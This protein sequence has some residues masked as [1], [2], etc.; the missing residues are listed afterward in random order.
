MTVVDARKAV[1]Q[2]I[3]QLV[4]LGG[5]NRMLYYRDLTRGTIR[6]D[7]VEPRVIDLLLGGTDTGLKSYAWTDPVG[8]ARR[9]K[10]IRAKARENLEEEGVSTLFLAMGLA[11]WESSR[12]Q[13]PAAPVVFWPLNVSVEF[14]GG[15][16]SVQVV[17]EPEVNPA[18]ELV[19]ELD[20]GVSLMDP[21]A[22]DAGH[23]LRDI[24]Q[25][26][27][28]IDVQL[29]GV[30]GFSLNRYPIIIGNFSYEKLAMV[31][32]LGIDPAGLLDHPLVAAIAGDQSAG[33]SLAIRRPTHDALRDAENQVNE[34]L[35]L[36]ADPTQ[37]AI[38]GRVLAGES[39]VIEGPPGTGKSQTIAN[40]V[41]THAAHGRSVLFVA[42]KRAAID[43]VLK[44]LEEVGLANLVLDLHGAT[45][46]R[47]R[48]ASVLGEAVEQAEGWR[49]HANTIR[50]AGEAGAG[51][52]GARLERHTRALHRVDEKRGCSVFEALEELGVRPDLSEVNLSEA[53]GDSMTAAER[54]RLVGLLSEWADRGGATD[55]PWTRQTDAAGAA[56]LADKTGEVKTRLLSLYSDL[57][58]A[59]PSVDWMQSTFRQAEKS[60]RV[61]GA[62]SDLLDRYTIGILSIDAASALEA[63]EAGGPEEFTTTRRS[64]AEHTKADIAVEQVSEDLL[65]VSRVR[66]AADALALDPTAESL[67]RLA[68]MVPKMGEAAR[69]L[70][71]IRGVVDSVLLDRPFRELLAR[72]E[73]LVEQRRIATNLPEIH[74]LERD[75]SAAGLDPVL[76]AIRTGSETTASSAVARRA[77]NHAMLDSMLRD[78]STLSSFDGPTLSSSVVSFRELENRRLDAAPGRIQPGV[79]AH[80]ESAVADHPG[81]LQAVR[82]EANKAR[83]HAPLRGIIEGASDVLLAARPC[84]AMSPLMVSQLLPS[85]IGL[86]DVVVFDEASQ[87]FPADALPAIFRGKQVVIAGDR[88]QLPPTTFFMSGLG[89]DEGVADRD[90]GLAADYQSILD[91]A[92]GI[93][94]VGSLGWHYRSQDDRLVAYSNTQ[95]Y[96]GALLTFPGVGVTSAV[97]HHLVTE[98][99]PKD[100]TYSNPHEVAEVVDLILEHARDRPNESLGVVAMGLEH[101]TEITLSVEDRLRGVDSPVIR[102]FFEDSGAERFLVKNLERIQGDERDAI[103]VSLGYAPTPDGKL[104]HNFGPINQVGG[105]RRLNVAVTRAK[106]RMTVVSSFRAADV[107]LSRSRSA[108]VRALKGF[109]Q[110]A[111]AGGEPVG[112]H[113]STD[114]G[115]MVRTITGRLTGAGLVAREMYGSSAAAVDVAVADPGDP[116]RFVA[117]ITLDGRFYASLPTPGDR[118]RL[119]AEVLERMGWRVYPTWALAWHRDPE[120]ELKRLV[121][122]IASK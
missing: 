121:E 118:D 78:N 43:A 104:R 59:V 36:D 18:L 103:I 116:G 9:I 5:R 101:A 24:G 95:F 97:Q 28:D 110:Y 98:P 26:F 19:M 39:L 74:R 112:G 53:A 83:R 48:M 100:R 46:T 111:E 57:A 91:L 70:R 27:D 99:A 7:D 10:A 41:A 65:L 115:A 40:L 42:E 49:G 60:C 66:E 47:R 85:M 58:D 113:T 20:F 96:R 73:A 56:E 107:D 15:E 114:V 92:Y 67:S 94:P 87:V 8:A 122:L 106:R 90:L 64:L 68:G 29:A 2:W 54:E 23:S 120:A 89:E 55:S 4:D 3:K 119:R 1:D 71:R 32:D 81:Q 80:L 86:F 72:L 11:T 62:A 16:P 52:P 63:L 12:R 37:R 30:P 14:A 22:L 13:D 84:W 50:D 21:E 117:A 82:S 45:T 44:R 102:S 51:D 17:G 75:L 109:L 25:A 61:A 35:I 6:L 38:L 31:E 69:G 93:L 108:G 76:E 77:L 33:E 105:E 79:A 88:K 34:H